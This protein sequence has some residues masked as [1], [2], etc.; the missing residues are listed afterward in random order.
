[1]TRFQGNFY[2]WVR[3]SDKPARVQ[4]LQIF[5]WSTIPLTFS[6][7]YF[8]QLAYQF[9]RTEYLP[10]FFLYRDNMAAF[11]SAVVPG[12]GLFYKGYRLPG[13]GYFFT[14]MSLAGYAV[15]NWDRGNRGRYALSAAGIIKLLEI[16]NAYL[17]PSSYRFFNLEVDRSTRDFELSVR[18]RSIE[19]DSGVEGILD[20]ALETLF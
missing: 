3:D 2:P 12:G 11:L 20:I 7:G 5:L 8:D 4:N 1:M 9:H 15:Y 6:A 17:I 13:W 19:R 18:T 10:P 16:V 14:E